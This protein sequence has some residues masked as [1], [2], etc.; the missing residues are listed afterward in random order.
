M[1]VM[2]RFKTWLD[3]EET[4]YSFECVECRHEFDLPVTDLNEA[5]CPECESHE[6]HQM[7]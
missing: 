3:D 7:L 6:V 5:I 1:G 2:E 4:T